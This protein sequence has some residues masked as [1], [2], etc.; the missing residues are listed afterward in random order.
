M[1]TL[2]GEESQYEQQLEDDIHSSHRSLG[3]M[4]S[5]K[6]SKLLKVCFTDMYFNDYDFADELTD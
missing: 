6:M 3:I 5:E 1:K 2:T 4:S